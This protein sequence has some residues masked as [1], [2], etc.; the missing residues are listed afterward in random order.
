M[1]SDAH[2]L[3]LS[4]D[5]VSTAPASRAPR[6]IASI[7]T[8]EHIGW[9]VL[10][11]AIA[12]FYA[13]LHNRHWVMGGD[14]DVFLSVARS[15][16][17]GEGYRFNGQPVAIIPPGWVW[18]LAGALQVTTRFAILKLIP[19][20][21]LVGFLG[22]SYSVLRR[23][24]SPAVAA[25]CVLTAALI[26]HAFGL[27]FLFYSDPLFALLAM[28]ALWL[29]I[30]VNEG[31][32]SGWRIGLLATLCVASVMTRWTG[33]LWCV[34]VCAA[35]VSGELRPRWNRRWAAAAL[36]VLV[37]LATFLLLR[38]ALR[39][40][41]SQLDP[42]YDPFVAERYDLF[43]L[44][45]AQ[46]Q[47]DRVLHAGHW[48]GGLL[49]RVLVAIRATRE[50]ANILG[51]I[52]I[53][54]LGVTLIHATRRRNW[55]PLAA[56]LYTTVLVINWPSPVPRYILPLAPLILLG[57]YKGIIQVGGLLPQPA[58]DMRWVAVQYLLG[59]IVVTN[60]I[61]YG[62]E[63]RVSRSGDLMKRHQA[64]YHKEL[65]DAAWWLNQ[66]PRE[67]FEIAISSKI[68]NFGNERFTDGF[69]RALNVLTNRAIVTVPEELCRE[70]DDEFIAWAAAHNV[71]YYLYEPPIELINHFH[72][73]GWHGQ[74]PDKSATA[75][76]LYEF[77]NGEVWR[78]L[79]PPARRWPAQVPGM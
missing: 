61:L 59:G 78:I 10:V 72:R 35:L 51:W 23:W 77:R 57:V 9:I 42:R 26:E 14:G 3:E 38:W 8:R 40:D 11:V 66:Q 24:A 67:G 30:R 56:M 18:V 41:P 79:V 69:R 22:L 43:N 33:V 16:A 5:P 20:A 17:L 32:D 7:L 12:V 25:V 39:V 54:L 53:A 13:P 19:A 64:G 29:A 68:K 62:I 37:T 21:C 50:I 48:I 73:T 75:W 71:R 46:G 65:V 70:P 60:L 27:A 44:E 58:R 52:A 55:I 47:I 6:A 49:W 36:C 1:Q 34:L 63:V 2:T 15:L 31:A 28:S 45:D 74:R 4:P 76:R